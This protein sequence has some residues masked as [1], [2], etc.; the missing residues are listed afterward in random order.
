LSVPI[1]PSKRIKIFA[2]RCEQEVGVGESF[3]SASLTHRTSRTIGDDRVHDRRKEGFWDGKSTHH[4]RHD[5]PLNRSFGQ[6]SGIGVE[7]LGHDVLWCRTYRMRDPSD[8][9]E[10]PRE[11]GGVKEVEVVI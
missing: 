1:I 10:R 2:S 9:V 4:G 6:K 7:E 5:I 11:E 3:V 8:K